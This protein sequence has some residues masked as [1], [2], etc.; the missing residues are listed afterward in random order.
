MCISDFDIYIRITPSTIRGIEKG[1]VLNI[2]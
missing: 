2:L 1:L